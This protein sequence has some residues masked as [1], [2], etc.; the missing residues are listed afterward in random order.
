MVCAPFEP[1]RSTIIAILCGQTVL[2]KIWTST[3]NITVT[4]S[5]LCKN[6]NSLL[7]QNNIFLS[8]SNETG[9]ENSFFSKYFGIKLVE[10]MLQKKFTQFIISV[11]EVIFNV[12]PRAIEQCCYCIVNNDSAH[13]AVFSPTLRKAPS[14]WQVRSKHS[15]EFKFNSHQQWVKCKAVT[16]FQDK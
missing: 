3:D 4:Y 16:G 12:G 14:I 15:L 11:Q 13:P 8:H 1:L 9:S 2:V 6:G 7:I 5:F 10:L